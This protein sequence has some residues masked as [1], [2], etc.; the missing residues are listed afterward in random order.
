MDRQASTSDVKAPQNAY[1]AGRMGLTTVSEPVHRSRA[2]LRWPLGL[3]MTVLA[4]IFSHEVVTST[5]SGS[6]WSYGLDLAPW[7]HWDTINYLEISLGGRNFGRCGTAAFPDSTTGFLHS[8]HVGQTWCGYAAWLPGFPWL[9][10]VVHRLGIPIIPAGTLVAQ[11]AW[12]ASIFLIWLG[13]ARSLKRLKALVLMLSFSVFPGAVYA[14]AFFPMSLTLALLLG[15]LVAAK[16]GWWVL[17]AP[18]LFC[19]NLCYPSSWYATVGIACGLFLYRRREG[20]LVSLRCAGWAASALLAI[21]ALMVHDQIAFRHWNAFF[22]LEAQS[23]PP[24][25]LPGIPSFMVA[26]LGSAGV[27]ELVLQAAVA[28]VIVVGALTLSLRA[29]GRI[30]A[31][32]DI[33]MAC[34]GIA[35]VLGLM[36][37]TTPGSWER[38]VLMAAPALL[39]LRRLPTLA[40]LGVLIV[41]SVV[42]A[43]LSRFYFTNEFI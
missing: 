10:S 24:L 15:G 11:L 16:R 20:W 3:G 43:V 40:L 27:H 29:E 19:A 5:T 21:P 41:L 13:W 34:G 17:M 18:L 31:S 23:R 4:W 38:G 37:T 42:T 2:A 33:V 26:R 36:V 22:V 7:W 25:Y 6:R 14:M 28:I 39:C 9:A 35:T 8:M 12:A 1:H 30:D 32:F